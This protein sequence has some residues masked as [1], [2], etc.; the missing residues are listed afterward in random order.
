[1]VI[2]WMRESLVLRADRSV[3]WP[4][5][6]TLFVAD[7]HFGKAESFRAAGLPIPGTV[8]HTL[9]RL[10]H[11]LNATGAQRLV[12]L[13]DFWHDQIGQTP[14]VD[15]NLA[16]WRDHH[17]DLRI[18]LVRG[19]HD[20]MRPPSSWAE[21]WQNAP[22]PVGPFRCVHHCEPD[23]GGPILAGHLHPGVRMVGAG[24]QSLR[25]PAFII[26]VNLLT[27][28]AFGSMTGLAIQEAMPGRRVIAIAGDAVIELPSEFVGQ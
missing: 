28:P 13:G 18:E 26:D 24:R 19:N 2:E 16:E 27:L 6:H 8:S 10:T 12:V 23:D 1:L 4:R 15:S 5:E 20:R 3:H 14:L 25:V 9:S 7:L 11:A 17:R 22:C 21:H